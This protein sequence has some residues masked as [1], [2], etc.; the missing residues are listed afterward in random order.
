MPTP[1]EILAA[2]V[3]GGRGAEEADALLGALVDGGVYVPVDNQGSVMFVGVDDS[4]PVLPGYPDEALCGRWLPTAAGAVKCDA[5]RLLDIAQHTG[6][7]TLAVFGDELWVK[8]PMGLIARTLRDRG[9][10]TRGEQTVQLRRSTHPV[11]MALRSAVAARILS[12]PTIRTVWI[13]HARFVETGHEQIMLHIAVD[14]PEPDAA[15]AL[16]DAVIGTEVTLGPDDPTVARRVLLP[17]ESDTLEAID[18]MGLDTVRADHAASRVT[19]V[20]REFDG[21]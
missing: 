17:H 13:G 3:D 7:A 20:S 9:I 18:R 19:V 11:A 16:L 14:R 5:L 21:D 2:I 12:H 15:K 8:V 1:E 10:R 6:V 4:G